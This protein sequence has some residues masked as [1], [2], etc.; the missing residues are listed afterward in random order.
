MRIVYNFDLGWRFH[1]GELENTELSNTHSACYQSCKAGAAGGG[2]KVG[3][4]DNDWRVVDLPHDY[5]SE[6]EM[7]P[8]NLHS[9][10]YRKRDNA[11]YRKSF[12]LDPSLKDKA[13]TLCF[14][15]TAVDAEFYFNGSLMARTFSAYTE[16]TFDITDRAYFD[17]RPNILAVHINGFSTEGWWYEGAGIYRHVKLYVTDP[18]HIAHNGIFAK[19]ILK[20]GT[21][22]SWVVNLTTTLNNRAYTADSACVHATLFDGDT[23][24]AESTSPLT[25]VDGLTQVDTKQKLAVSRPTRWDV[26]NPKLYDL[27][28]SIVKNGKVV[29]NDTVRIGFRTFSIDPDKGFF[30]NERPL[31]IK[32]TCNHQ[33]HAG[34]GVAVPDAVQ[35]YRIQRLKE[36]GTNA[37]RC[38]H[39]LPT[40]E[41]LD[42]CDQLGLIVMDENR[43]FETREEVLEFLRIMVKR[44]RNHP[45]VM[46]YSLFNEEP[47][48]DVEEGGRIFRHMRKVVE[49]L[50]DTRLIT[51]AMNSLDVSHKGAGEYMDVIGKNYGV[52]DERMDKVHADHPTRALIGSEN[53]SAVTTRGCYKSDHESA[54]VLSQ[55][56]GEEVVP[57][58]QSIAQTWDY[59]RK[60]DFFAGIFVW[61][62]FD[63][64]G[65]PTPFKW[66]SVS[67]QFGI[68]DSCGFPK[69]AFYYHKACFTDKP[70]VHL[71]PHWNWKEGDIVRVVAITNCEEVELFV[72][73]VSLG[74]KAADVCD[75]PL[76]EVPFHKG[77]IEAKAYKNGKCVARD[78]QRTTGKPRAVKVDAVCDYVTDDG[79]DALILNCSVVDARGRVIPTAT[80]HLTFEIEGDG[81]LLGVGNGNPNSHESDVLPERDLFAGHCQTIIRVLPGAKTLKIRVKSDKLQEAEFVPAI[82]PVEAPTYMPSCTDYLLRGITQSE[83]TTDRPDPLIVL[84]DDNQN[85][86]TPP[87]GLGGDGYPGDYRGG[88]RIWRVIPT[89]PKCEKDKIYTLKFPEV[90]SNILEVYVN[91]E[92]VLNINKKLF[93]DYVT[94]DFTIKA[95]AENAEVRI[96]T[97]V[98]PTVFTSGFRFYAMSLVDHG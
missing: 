33:D 8:D 5:L 58:G 40:K 31:K 84:N 79:Q 66:P 3:F 69:E 57:W 72:N 78:V 6:S 44:D 43:R 62:G 86:F 97:Y 38:A 26:D 13:L 70:M 36:M 91:G 77:R 2:A 65:E 32:G 12:T 7:G 16:T 25:T 51:G 1:R 90:R 63:Y 27:H 46:F 80:N 59:T 56:D 14:E 47:L 93:G 15:G 53:N 22:N 92:K 18:L 48:Q 55:Y 68:M 52:V 19:P 88:W 41:I 73:G 87:A 67:S 28:I 17:G 94:C 49:Q 89:V 20:K 83:V 9:H 42:A 23:V 64:R 45:S 10:G 85:S 61:T 37:Y 81:V 74:K 98:E 34:V 24:V 35:H 29:D 95:G 82:I 54:Q 60:H 71:M 11:W 50:D 30:L 39:N 4:S 96:L 75:Q 76:W 21:K